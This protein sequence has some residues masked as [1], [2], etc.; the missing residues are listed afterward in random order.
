MPKFDVLLVHTQTQNLT[1]EVSAKDDEAAQEKVE[2]AL[3][4]LEYNPDTIA[5]KFKSEW[6]EHTNDFDIDS[7]E[8]Q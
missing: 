5:A 1:I 4:D 8:E 7:V 3:Q 2:K 6:E